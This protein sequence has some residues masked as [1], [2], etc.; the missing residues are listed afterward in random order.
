MGEPQPQVGGRAGRAGDGVVA[1]SVDMRVVDAR[2]GDVQT[3]NFEL[4]AGMG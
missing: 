1:V 3:G 4:A 2:S